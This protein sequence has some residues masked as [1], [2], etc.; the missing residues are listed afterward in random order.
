MVVR[1]VDV[2]H[3]DTLPL[4]SGGLGMPNAI[5]HVDFYPNGG[6]SNPGCDKPMEHYILSTGTKQTGFFLNIIAF[7]LKEE[8]IFFN[9][10]YI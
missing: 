6:H 1:F 3:S 9:L 8:T 5:G 4:T 7:D 10:N 2:I